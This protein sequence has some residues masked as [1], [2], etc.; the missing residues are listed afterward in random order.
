MSLLL[1]SVLEIELATWQIGFSH[2]WDFPKPPGA[3]LFFAH[4]LWTLTSASVS[5]A[6]F[7]FLRC[8]QLSLPQHSAYTPAP[9]WRSSQARL[10]VAAASLIS[11][12][13]YDLLERAWIFMWIWSSPDNFFHRILV[14]SFTALIF[15]NYSCLCVSFSSTGIIDVIYGIRFLMPTMVSGTLSGIS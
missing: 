8:C 15:S 14:V 6:V 3:L 4:R 10:S 12:P 1:C 5:L 11:Q 9:L 13:E 2:S 7:Q